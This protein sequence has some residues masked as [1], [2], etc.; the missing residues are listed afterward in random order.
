M[1]KVY[2]ILSALLCIILVVLPVYATRYFN[3]EF[4]NDITIVCPDCDYFT[5]CQ[6]FSMMPTLDCNDTLI[7]IRPNSR[8]D[9]QVG[10]IIT[11][12]GSEEQLANYEGIEYVTH[13]IIG[14]DHRGCYETKGDNNYVVDS[15]KPCFYDIKFKVVGIIYE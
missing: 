11:Y 7:V 13:R 14:T 2:V 5:S 15:F 4:D 6:S 8:K 3:Y 12:R 10:D 1:K 9:I